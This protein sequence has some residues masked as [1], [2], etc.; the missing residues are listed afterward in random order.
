VP[1]TTRK[2]RG[3]Q[4]L[5]TVLAFCLMASALLYLFLG[6][7]AVAQAWRMRR[8]CQHQPV[9][10]QALASDPRLR[11]IKISVHTTP[12]GAALMIH[13]TVASDPDLQLLTELVRSTH[14][15]CHVNFR[16]V[17]PPK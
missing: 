4:F 14:P 16:V 7:T 15:P 10:E 12:G 6:D 11:G 3:A 9:I 8:A 17:V 5:A 13:G 1:E 2:L